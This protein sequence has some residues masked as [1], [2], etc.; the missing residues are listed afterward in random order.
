MAAPQFRQLQL[1]DPIIAEGY[2]KIVHTLF[3]NHNIYKRLQSI[4][5]RGNKE[6]WTMKGENLSEAIERDI[7]S[8]MLSAEKQCNLR[9]MHRE[10]WSPAI[11]FGT[12]EIRY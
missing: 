9:K 6:D 7:T 5:S 4:S 3:T 12:N 1:D 8:S 10:P 11:G 2:G